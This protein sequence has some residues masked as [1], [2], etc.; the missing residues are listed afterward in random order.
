MEISDSTDSYFAKMVKVE[1]YPK[2][3]ICLLPG[4]DGMWEA[5]YQLGS[6]AENIALQ[7][8]DRMYRGFYYRLSASAPWFFAHMEVE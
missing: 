1:E 6:V 7:P 2:G 8:G 5:W 3:F 4:G